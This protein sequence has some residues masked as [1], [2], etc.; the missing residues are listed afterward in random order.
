MYGSTWEQQKSGLAIREDEFSW[1]ASFK[2]DPRFFLRRIKAEPQKFTD[3][4]LGDVN[5]DISSMLL[6]EFLEKTGWMNWDYVIFEGIGKVDDDYPK[7]VASFD[8]IVSVS[9]P[10][11]EAIGD[12]VQNSFLKKDADRWNVVLSL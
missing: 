3:V 6:S 9:K 7:T 2:S 4:L 10:A 1:Q 12:Q 8:R 11:F 5:D